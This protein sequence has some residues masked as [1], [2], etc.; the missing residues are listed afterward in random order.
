M[1]T[2]ARAG[3]QAGTVTVHGSAAGF[4]QEIAIGRHR[5]S[6]DEPTSAGGTDMGPNPYDFLLAALGSCTSMTVA[7]YARRKRWP[8]E[9]VTVRLRH[10]RIYAVD[11]EECE[12]TEGLLDHIDCD[13]ELT[14]VLTD[15]QCERL[16]EIADKCP[17]HRTLTS[18]I[19]ILTR[20]ARPARIPS[21]RSHDGNAAAP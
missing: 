18:E 11:C 5:L 17:V 8:L 1:T 4:A 15:E 10:S 19:H 13:V 6:G 21:G 7:M 2:I 3:A 16:L 9:A 12:A 14:G 20:L